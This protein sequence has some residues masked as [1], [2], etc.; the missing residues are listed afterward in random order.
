MQ[1]CSAGSGGAFTIES[2]VATTVTNIASSTFADNVAGI[3]EGG[4]FVLT[5]GFH[6]IANST[7]L[8]NSAVNGGGA[9]TFFTLCRDHT[10][11]STI[12]GKSQVRGC[13]PCPAKMPH[14]A[15]FSGQ[16]L[17]ALFS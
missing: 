11:N 4:V 14:P 5:G 16:G 6:T 12:F 1:C 17:L 13:L 15:L 2:G 7:F 3:A 8:R 10:E 9:I